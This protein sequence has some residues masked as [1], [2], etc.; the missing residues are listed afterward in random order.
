MAGM[1]GYET[2]RRIRRESGG[3]DV[4]IVALTGW[5]QQ[6]DKLRAADAGFDAHLIKPADPATLVRILSNLDRSRPARSEV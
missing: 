4:F 5:G 2:C 1:D 3:S 6:Q